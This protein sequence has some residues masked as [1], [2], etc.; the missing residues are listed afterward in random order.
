[1]SDFGRF[2]FAHRD[3]QQMLRYLVEESVWETDILYNVV[4]CSSLLFE[5]KS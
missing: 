4:H 1:M 5:G 2:E 3:S